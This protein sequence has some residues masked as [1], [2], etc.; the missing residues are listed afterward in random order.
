MAA[1]REGMARLI[2]LLLRL[3]SPV[4]THERIQLVIDQLQGISGGDSSGF[5]PDKVLSVPDAVATAL[6]RL[7]ATETASGATF[8]GRTSQHPPDICPR[9]H[10]ATVVRTEGCE[11]CFDCGWSK[12]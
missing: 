6:Q 2:S 11:K 5:G 7:T 3:N 12:C 10:Q 8:N 9:C 4:P 1:D